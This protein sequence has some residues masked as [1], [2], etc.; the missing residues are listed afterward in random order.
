[1]SDDDTRDDER[2]QKDDKMV[3]L[4][5][6]DDEAVVEGEAEEGEEDEDSEEPALELYPNGED[7][8]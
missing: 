1:M 6:G 5:E 4:P 3:T 8:D 2:E 7:E